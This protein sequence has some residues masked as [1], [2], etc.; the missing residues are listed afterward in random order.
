MSRQELKDKAY[1]KIASELATLGTCLRLKVGCLLL[2]EEGR[3]VAAGYNGSGP[4][5]LHCHPDT[6][7]PEHRCLRCSHAEENAVANM[8]GRPHTAYVTHEPCGACTRKLILAGVRRIVFSKPYT[9][10]SEEEKQARL[11]WI[12]H[13]EV[14]L[15]QCEL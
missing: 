2:S 11:E 1:L 5:M 3:V 4:G 10:M 6:C 8:S 14:K 9:S 13:Y 12:Y 7:G 15:E